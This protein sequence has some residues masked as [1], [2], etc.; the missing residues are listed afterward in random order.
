[1]DHL[2]RC[3]GCGTYTLKSEC[4]ACGTATCSPR[5]ARFSPDDK[6]WKQRLK[7]KGVKLTC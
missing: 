2:K 6:Y 1:M 3:N 5:P 4:P 7:A